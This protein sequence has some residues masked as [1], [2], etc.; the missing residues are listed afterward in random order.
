[1]KN[2]NLTTM[3]LVV[4]LLTISCNRDDT[5]YT[6]DKEKAPKKERLYGIKKVDKISTKAVSLSDKTWESGDTIRIR[7]LNGSVP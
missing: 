2:L 3:A 1:M 6:Q 5:V 7:F 4:I